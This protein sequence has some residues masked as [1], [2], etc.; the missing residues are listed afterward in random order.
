M[1]QLFFLR[2]QWIASLIII[3]IFKNYLFYFLT[4]KTC[5]IYIELLNLHNYAWFFYRFF[6]IILI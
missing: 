4:R 3:N 5:I 6:K 1:K 2:V